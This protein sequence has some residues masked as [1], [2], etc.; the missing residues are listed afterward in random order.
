MTQTLTYLSGGGKGGEV[1][2]GA[3]AAQPKVKDAARMAKA[4]SAMKSRPSSNF[5]MMCE[6]TRHDFGRE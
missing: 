1:V 5:S 6:Q 2:R 3:T 4:P